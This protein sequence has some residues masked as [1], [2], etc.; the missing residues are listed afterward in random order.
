MAPEHTSR[1]HDLT[2]ALHRIDALRFFRGAEGDFW[3]ALLQVALELAPATA[4]VVFMRT[5]ATDAPMPWK[6]AFSW[7]PQCGLQA[8]LNSGE[9]ERFLLEAESSGA[10]VTRAGGHIAVRLATSDPRHFVVIVA[11]LVSG[12]EAADATGRL[13]LLGDIPLLYERTGTVEKAREDMTRF[14]VTLDVLAVLNVQTE[15]AAAAMTLC[16]EL[17]ARFQC[18]RVSFGWFRRGGVKLEAV[19]H[20]ERFEKNMSLVTAI[21]EAMDEAFDQEEEIAWPALA[22]STA[23][24]R[25]HEAFARTEAGANVLSMPVPLND[26]P[27]GVL[28]LERAHGAFTERELQTLRMLCVQI[29]RRLHELRDFDRWWGAR[30]ADAVRRTAAKSLGAEHTLAKLCIIVITTLIL[31]LVFVKAEH[32][33]DASFILKSETL[34]QLPAPFDGY[35]DEVHFRVGDPVRAGQLLVT[36]DSRELLLNEAA[37]L[38]EKQRF[39]AEE[40]KAQAENNS[41]LMRI[42]HASAEEAQA[43]LELARFRLSKASVIAPFDGHVIEGDLRE[44]IASPVRQGEV[45]LK[46]ARLETM[47][48]EISLPEADVHHVAAAMIGEL[49]FASRPQFKFPVHIERVEPVATVRE[50]GNTFTARA[51][52]NAMEAWWRPGMSGV[53]KVNAGRRTLLWIYTHRTADFLRL[54]LWW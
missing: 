45:L 51:E 9:L 17:S 29:A 32:R 8:T 11:Q 47:F 14:A 34:V 44:H 10:G 31:A 38:A 5:R 23:V 19:S 28:T 22:G 46:I 54:H 52:F 3:S 18:E 41:A 25:S 48:A 6:D 7:P 53:C 33:I 49:A 2:N 35:I 40:Q 12:T 15:F 1:R 20:T 30:A 39:I 42:A 4:A 43:K 50:K 27:V 21:E 26:E 36:L 16:N 24:S 37:A 13:R